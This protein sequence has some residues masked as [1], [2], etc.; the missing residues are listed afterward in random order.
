MPTRSDPIAIAELARATA[1]AL[2]EV[3]AVRPA[4]PGAATTYGPGRSV[5]G[6]LVDPKGAVG[7]VELHLVVRYGPALVEV[8]DHVRAAVGA[9]L[10]AAAPDLAP[11][12]VDIEIADLV[13]TE[14][15]ESLRR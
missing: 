13:E 7:R 12:T 9:A 10:A 11:W 6:A 5:G 3:V 8:G 4:R 15:V 2:D 1:L 14:D